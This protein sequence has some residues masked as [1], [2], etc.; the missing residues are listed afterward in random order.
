MAQVT[1]MAQVWSLTQEVPHAHMPLGAAKKKKKKKKVA[2]NQEVDGIDWE[3]PEESENY[4]Q[5]AL[6]IVLLLPSAD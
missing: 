3:W 2:Q 1:A 6:L 4:W 5:L